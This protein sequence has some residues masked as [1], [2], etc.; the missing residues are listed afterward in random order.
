MNYAKK[1]ISE[2]IGPHLGR[3]E[4]IKKSYSDTLDSWANWYDNLDVEDILPTAYTLRHTEEFDIYNKYI[5]KDS[6]ILEA[7]CGLGNQVIYLQR[8]GFNVFGVDQAE[9]ALKKV[10]TYDPTLP[11]LTADI[12]KLPFSNSSFDVYLSFGVLEHFPSGPMQ[13]L[14]EAN[15]I[16][17]KNGIIV[18][19][20]PGSYLLSR[21][22]SGQSSDLYSSLKNSPLLRKIFKKPMPQ[23]PIFA[24]SYSK[25]R[26]ANFLEEAG[27]TI[28][29]LL[30]TGHD[31]I[32][33]TLIPFFR[34]NN[35]GIAKPVGVKVAHFI[36]RFFPWRT[37]FYTFVLARKTEDINT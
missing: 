13:A 29:K 4:K 16:L 34:Q 30:P 28:L 15:R 18:V 35:L 19:T 10:K 24:I 5:N 23:K 31:F 14:K 11:V 12:H 7:G 9:G 21:I 6:R 36:R 33:Y 37:S 25:E 3:D 8:K 1:N 27:F 2:N 20:M 26:I 17:T 22:A 32:W